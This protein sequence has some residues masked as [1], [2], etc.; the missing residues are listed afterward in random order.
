M[1][2]D[3]LDMRGIKTEVINFII[4]L[5]ARYSLTPTEL[6]WI[7]ASEFAISVT[8]TLIDL[9]VDQYNKHKR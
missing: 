5:L 7:V 6:A 8:K 1:Y 2:Y 9:C 4:E 3:E